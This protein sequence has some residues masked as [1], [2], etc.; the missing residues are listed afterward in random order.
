MRHDGKDYLLDGARRI[1]D[2][3]AMGDVGPHPVIIL[4]VR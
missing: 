2:W 1:N 4:R 3:Q